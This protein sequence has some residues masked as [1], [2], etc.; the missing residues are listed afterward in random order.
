MPV[1]DVPSLDDFYCSSV[2]RGT[3]IHCRRKKQYLVIATL[4]R[5][6]TDRHTLCANCCNVRWNLI[7]LMSKKWSPGTFRLRSFQLGGLDNKLDTLHLFAHFW[8][9][10][11]ESVKT[12][13]ASTANT[14][15]HF[16]PSEMYGWCWS[17]NGSGYVHLCWS[18][19]VTTTTF[20]AAGAGRTFG[21]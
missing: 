9:A 13:T 17:G 12:A 8:I 11:V 5:L 15:L 10:R 19:P 18:P 4:V 7:I 21:T 14:G 3:R 2:K 20:I 6:N 16:S 1:C